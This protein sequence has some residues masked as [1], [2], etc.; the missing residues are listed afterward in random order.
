MGDDDRQSG[1]EAESHTAVWVF[2]AVIL[3][4]ILYVLSIGPVIAIAEKFDHPHEPYQVFYA[5][6]GWL[7]DH[8][9]LQGPLRKYAS[10]WGWN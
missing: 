8:T 2:S 4:P 7:H 3:L 9:P 10:W 6:V 1:N 5:P